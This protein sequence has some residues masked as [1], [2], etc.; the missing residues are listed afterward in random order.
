M[1]SVA[2][3]GNFQIGKSSLVNALLQKNVSQT[4]NGLAT[5]HRNRCH[6]LSPF[7]SL[8]DTPGLNAN[9]KDNSTAD[10]AVSSA[11]V[12]VYV[13]ES[14][15]LG[16]ETKRLEELIHKGKM[17]LFLLNCKNREQWDPSDKQNQRIV[18]EI[19]AELEL[20]GILD[21]FLRLGSTVVHPVN[22]KWALYGL[23]LLE[24]KE[25]VKMPRYAKEN[26]DIQTE[27][28]DSPQALR[29][30]MMQ[31]SGFPAI[32]EAILNLPYLLLHEAA[33]NPEREIARFVAIFQTS[34]A[35][36][37]LAG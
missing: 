6:K 5:T 13:H 23:G 19:E 34:F 18:Q 20:N 8:I 26:L 22:L 16:D 2:I 3:I 17:I 24:Q 29:E 30:R 15:M 11:D 21:G 14:K 31:S 36:S 37:K 12:L 7:V 4:G 25:N 27:I 33:L 1:I 32:R 35:D 10:K 28:A 9:D